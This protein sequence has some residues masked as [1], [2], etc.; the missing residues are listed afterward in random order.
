MNKYFINLDN[1]TKPYKKAPL[2]RG[3][4]RE[5]VTGGSKGNIKSEE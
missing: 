5:C 2:I 1:L 4:A 3:L